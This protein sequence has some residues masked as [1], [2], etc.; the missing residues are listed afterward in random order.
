MDL[1]IFESSCHLPSC[2]SQTVEASHCPFNAE[3][4]AGKMGMPIFI[5]LGLTRSGIKPERTFSLKRSLLRRG[6]TPPISKFFLRV[7]YYF[8]GQGNK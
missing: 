6:W 7:V 8:I 3:R 5:V 2:L 1:S 4:Q